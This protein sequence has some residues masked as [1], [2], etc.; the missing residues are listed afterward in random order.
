[1]IGSR[2]KDA[3]INLLQTKQYES[4]HALF[5]LKVLLSMTLQQQKH[6]MFNKWKWLLFSMLW[7]DMCMD[8]WVRLNH[9]EVLL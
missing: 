8:S 1:M 3:I 9:H 4:C 6:F 2:V 7:R 5:I